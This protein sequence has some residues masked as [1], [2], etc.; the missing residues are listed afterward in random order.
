MQVFLFMADK[1]RVQT[2]VTAELFDWP[3]A[4]ET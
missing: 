4:R 1:Y 3:L 2:R